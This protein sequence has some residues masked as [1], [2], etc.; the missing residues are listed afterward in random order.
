MPRIEAPSPTGARLLKRIERR[1]ELPDAEQR[2]LLKA[3][4]GFLDSFSPVKPRRRAAPPL[5]PR[6]EAI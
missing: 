2:A 5:P 6:R 3:V 4:D 1:A